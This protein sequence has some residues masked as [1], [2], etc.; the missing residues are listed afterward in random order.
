MIDDEVLHFIIRL[1]QLVA[2]LAIV[3]GL[4][5][6]ENR[7]IEFLVFI[8]ITFVLVLGSRLPQLPLSLVGVGRLPL[9]YLRDL[10]KR[11][12]LVSAE[13]ACFIVGIAALASISMF[14]RS[15]DVAI[16]ISYLGFFLQF[17]ARR[18]TA[19]ARR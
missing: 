10:M 1:Q 13:A 8:P 17:F 6:G 15:T 9:A 12:W 18:P 14:R 3:V 5:V 16:G 7:D 4:V 19:R 2:A 11:S